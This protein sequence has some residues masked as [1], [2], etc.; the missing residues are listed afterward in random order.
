MPP[1]VERGND[2]KLAGAYT[3]QGIAIA[4]TRFPNRRRVWC[5]ATTMKEANDPTPTSWSAQIDALSSGLD[6][7]GEVSRVIC[8]SAG[9][10]P[11]SHWL[12]YPTSNYTY[13]V[14]NPTQAWNAICVG[15]FTELTLIRQE[16]LFNPIAARGN[17]SPA[18]ST[19]LSWDTKW[20]NKPDVVFEG[21][22]AGHQPA[23]N[24]T[25]QLPEL[26]LLSTHADYSNGVF[27]VIG[28]TSP[29]TA[30]AARFG[31]QLM[32]AYPDLTPESVRGLIIHSADWTQSM[33]DSVP[34]AIRNEKRGRANFL[35]RTV[36][37][38]VP[39]LARALECASARATLIA[40]CEIQPFKLEGDE[41]LFNQM[42]IHNLPWPRLALERH[43]RE[44]VKMRVTLSYFIEPNPGTRGTSSFRYPSCALRFRV[45]SPGQTENDL[46]AD[47]NKFAMEE[48]VRQN[49]V[50]VAGSTD[51]WTLGQACFRGSVHSDIWD[52]SAADLLSMRYI[53]VSPVTGW[54]RTRPSHGKSNSSL[55]YSLIVTL[56]ANN[57]AIDLY[58]EIS[59]QIAVQVT[60]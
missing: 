41:V 10:L 29:A 7:N 39:S 48:F 4:E 51:G 59:N 31:G 3:A 20:P 55:P 6:N 46:A 35:L 26:M 16:E 34:D 32:A 28:G 36:G 9:N 43:A 21:G 37:Y 11:Q 1:P 5:I 58:T 52:G 14:E 47:V 22:N 19:S 27:G 42:H 60:Q 17:L 57:Q 53:A 38:G 8:M 33:K 12:Q 45:S 30:L 15:A 25:L 50:P 18:S 56:E 2:E 49:R 24:S 13:S 44:P 40:Q 23:N 54:W